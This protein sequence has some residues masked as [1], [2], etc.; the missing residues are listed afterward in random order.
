MATRKMLWEGKEWVR[1]GV[2]PMELF[3]FKD[4]KNI[5]VSQATDT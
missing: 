5:V 4:P 1:N 3:F 2:T